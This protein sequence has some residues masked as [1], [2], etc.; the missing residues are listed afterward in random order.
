MTDVE[1]HDSREA[2]VKLGRFVDEHSAT[3]LNAL[4]NQ[5]RH[6]NDAADLAKDAEQTQF[7]RAFREDADSA[8]KVFTELTDLIEALAEGRNE[9]FAN[10]G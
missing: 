8:F 5:S 6:M 4:G 9:D 7:E 3:L 10:Q 2:L 1:G